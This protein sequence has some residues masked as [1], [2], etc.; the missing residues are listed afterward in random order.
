MSAT[1]ITVHP[2]EERGNDL[3]EVEVQFADGSVGDFL[4][5]DMEPADVW[6][7][8]FSRLFDDLGWTLTDPGDFAWVETNDGGFVVTINSDIEKD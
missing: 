5:D 1:Q 3:I 6:G 7:P 2:L 8:L 4:L